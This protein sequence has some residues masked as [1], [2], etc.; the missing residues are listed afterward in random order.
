MNPPGPGEPFFPRRPEDEAKPAGEGGTDRLT[1]EEKDQRLIEAVAGRVV[2]MGMAVPAIFFLESTKPLSFVG[3]QALVF[4][5]PFVKSFLNLS[6]YD[7]FTRLMEDRKSIEKLIVRIEDLDEEAR[8][9]EKERRKRE[10]EEKRQKR[11]M[12]QETLSALPGAAPAGRLPAAAGR[13]RMRGWLRR[14]LRRDRGAG[15]GA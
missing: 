7:R 15:G 12:E 13:S 8:K 5:E 1:E 6:S 14:L 11:T 2:Q 10:K 9:A 4:L 3:S